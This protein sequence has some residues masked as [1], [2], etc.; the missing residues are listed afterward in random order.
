VSVKRLIAFVAT[1]LAFIIADNARGE[2]RGEASASLGYAFPAGSL[3]RGSRVSDTTYGAVPLA[4]DGAVFVTPRVALR[5]SA[6]FALAIPKLCASSSDCTA[7]LGNDIAV[8]AGVRFALPDLGPFAPR[9]DAGFGWEWYTTSLSEKGVASTRAYSGPT[10]AAL[11]LSAP[12]RISRRF[13]LG[14]MLGV[15]AGAFT[16]STKTTPSWTDSSLD[17]AALHAWLRASVVADLTF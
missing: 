8:D 6:A 7:S 5:L 12:L 15:R 14:P 9:F 3:E 11:A 10:F 4:I 1:I 16:S 17:G 13:T 2:E